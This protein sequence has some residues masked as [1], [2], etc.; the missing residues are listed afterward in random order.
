MVLL[1]LSNGQGRNRA[2]VSPIGSS[3]RGR[4][5]GASHREKSR[6]M[7]GNRPSA[8]GFRLS[9]PV[10]RRTPVNPGENTG[11]EQH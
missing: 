10:L 9:C 2:A 6:D 5:T 3:F 4:R 8:E 11:I 1:D 7:R